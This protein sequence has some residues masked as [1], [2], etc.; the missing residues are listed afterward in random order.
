MFLD[1]ARETEEQT[2]KI[3]EHVAKRKK[4]LVTLG[5]PGSNC[6]L[7]SF[8]IKLLTVPQYD[9]KCVYFVQGLEIS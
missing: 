8:L 3:N 1:F 6:L 9:K 7:R 2:T 5:N 4:N